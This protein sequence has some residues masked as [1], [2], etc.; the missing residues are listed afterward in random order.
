[1]SLE[2]TYGSL[3]ALLGAHTKPFL[4]KLA[5]NGALHLLMWDFNLGK[6]GWALLHRW[7]R[8]SFD[9]SFSS[10]FSI[11]SPWLLTSS[12]TSTESR[13]KAVLKEFQ[14]FL[15]FKYV[16]SKS[17]LMTCRWSRLIDGSYIKVFYDWK[18]CLDNKGENA[19]N[20]RVSH[21]VVYHQVLNE[22]PWIT[23][24]GWV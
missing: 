9:N 6:L 16:E 4:S 24:L 8:N 22:S 20:Q 5:G 21:Q 11:A 23:T 13:K 1:M 17:W 10:S 19:D 3:P 15:C 18:L 2:L 14:C 7:H 12:I